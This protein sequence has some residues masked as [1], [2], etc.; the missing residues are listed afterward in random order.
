MERFI[1]VDVLNE[2]AEHRDGVVVDVHERLHAIRLHGHGDALV[3]ESVTLMELGDGVEGVDEGVQ[4][5]SIGVG[6][7]CAGD[8]YITSASYCRIETGGDVDRL[9]L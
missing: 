6:V 2:V 4:L 9:T 1:E 3:P 5:G 8:G 7:V